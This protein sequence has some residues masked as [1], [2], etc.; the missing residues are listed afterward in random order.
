MLS[1]PTRLHS[2]SLVVT[3]RAEYLMVILWLGEAAAQCE[4]IVTNQDMWGNTGYYTSY[5]TLE[6]QVPLSQVCDSWTNRSRQVKPGKCAA[7]ERQGFQEPCRTQ[8]MF[9]CGGF[10]P[11]QQG[12]CNTGDLSWG[13]VL[14]REG[15]AP[16]RSFSW[17][18]P[19]NTASVSRV[20]VTGGWL[21]N[22]ILRRV[23]FRWKL[24]FHEN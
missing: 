20:S 12:W 6:L 11:G 3:M 2:Q 10:C 24:I 14:A 4:E 5:F 19:C 16:G 22:T 15:A 9:H 8:E 23:K 13:R 18:G 1:A 7:R 21:G 17:E